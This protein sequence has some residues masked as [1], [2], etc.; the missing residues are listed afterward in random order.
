MQ[1]PGTTKVTCYKTPLPRFQIFICTHVP[2]LASG[3]VTVT[4]TGF[5]SPV[6]A[7]FPLTQALTLPCWTIAVQSLSL[8]L[9]SPQMISQ[10]FIQAL[11]FCSDLDARSSFF[12]GIMEKLSKLL[13]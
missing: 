10:T 12:L 7:T 3:T 11:H 5:L 2:P 4:V 1:N 9:A 13:P 8:P 6:S